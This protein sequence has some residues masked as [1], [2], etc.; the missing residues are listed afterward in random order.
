MRIFA[1]G[2]LHLP[3]G[4]VKPMDVFGAHWAGHFE[5]IAADWRARVGGEDVVL[6]P[7]DLS[8]AMTLEEAAPDL[9]AVCDLPGKKIFLRGN[10]D[11]WW[12]SLTRLR[13]MLPEGA[14]ALQND[15]RVVGDAVFAGTRGWTVTP[16]ASGNERDQKI[17]RREVLRL[18][19]SLKD[20]V[21]R[22]GGRPIVVLLHFPPFGDKR[23][24]SGFTELMED[25]AVRHCVYGHLH[26][27]GLK[28]A[29]SG[30]RGGVMYHQVSCDGLH[31]KLHEFEL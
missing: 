15:A 20:A 13:G 25:Y 10:H 28:Y 14:F 22:G 2:D 4:Q 31:F 29:V 1:I 26:G 18:E 9:A 6:L 24:G 3:G 11:Y 23:E 16:P 12:S 30:E 7:G 21:H 19:L 27:E 8:W 17:Y 5:K